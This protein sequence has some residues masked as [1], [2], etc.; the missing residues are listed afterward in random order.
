MSHYLQLLCLTTTS[1][2]RISI[3]WQQTKLPSDG[4]AVKR[5]IDWLL[6]AALFNYRS[7]RKVYEEDDDL[8]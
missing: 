4:S 3:E 8:K 1:V 2:H 7:A 5:Q 6:V